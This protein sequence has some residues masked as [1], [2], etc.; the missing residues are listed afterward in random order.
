MAERL[1]SKLPAGVLARVRGSLSSRWLRVYGTFYGLH[2]ASRFGNVLRMVRAG[3][4]RKLAGKLCG[5]QALDQASA[6]VI[7]PV[8]V[9]R[10][11]PPLYLA[12]SIHGHGGYDHLVLKALV[13]LT[14]A[15]I[16]VFRDKRSFFQR[17]CI[18]P[19][20]APAE[21]LYDW[22]SSRLAI[23]PPYLLY[24]YKPTAATAAWTMWETDTLP[25]GAAK[26]LNRCGLLVIPSRWGADCF[27]ADG[28]TVPTEVVPLGYD[29]AVFAPRRPES[30][31]E[32]CTFGT[33][34]ALDEGGMRKNV[35]RVIDLF[36]AAFSGRTDVRLKVKITP[37]SPMV[38]THGDSRVEVVNTS[39]PPAALADWY[40]SLTCYVNASYG[41][42]FGLHLLEAMG[43]G[44][45]LIST[46]FSAVGEVFD[47]DVGYEVSYKLIEA[48]NAVYSG[49][50]A[51]PDND[52][53]IARMREVYSDPAGAERLGLAAARRAP[54]FS[55]AE[56]IR[57]LTAALAKHG[58]LPQSYAKRKPL[59]ADS[60]LIPQRKGLTCPQKTG[61]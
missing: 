47:S 54:A 48:K 22:R 44:V 20:Y 19:Q 58:Y 50:W 1:D 43:C 59:A 39:L 55:W 14:D 38:N 51:D 4:F 45:P 27:R 42:G 6:T 36:R 13:G 57:K 56:S 18:P 32:I 31:P 49:L 9:V 15:G 40:R 24:W 10:P 7:G 26:Y 12:G 60:D 35:Q 5:R 25:T 2:F 16:H 30:G 37:R 8:R 29:P 61:M 3:K 53:L 33:A 21:Q 28:V 11:G 41:E 46:T 23:V 34:G 52:E 17:G